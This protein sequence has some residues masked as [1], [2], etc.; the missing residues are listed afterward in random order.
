MILLRGKLVAKSPF[1]IGSGEGSCSDRDVLK[2]DNDKPFIPGTSLAGV[3]R[4]YFDGK[5]QEVIDE[6]FGKGEDKESKII[7]YDAFLQGKAH[8][9]VRDSVRLENRIAVDET[10]FD[11]EVI[12]E[13]ASFEFRLEI[14]YE[15]EI[16]K[17]LIKSI[18]EGF[19]RGEIR[20]GAKTSRGF[21]EFHV[22]GAV[23][24]ELDLS[25]EKDLDAYIDLEKTKNKHDIW[26]DVRE[27]KV[28]NKKNLVEEEK[29]HR[30]DS[31]V[32]LK[33]FLLIRDYSTVS[34]VTPKDNKS[35]FVD[36]ETLTNYRGDVV[37]PGTAWAGVF[38]H[39]CRRVLG[40]I[41]KREEEIKIFLDEYFGHETPLGE[42]GKLNHDSE[43]EKSKSKIIFSETRICKDSLTQ[44]NRTRTAIDRVSGSALQTGA[45]YTERA[46][47][48]KE[49]KKNEGD[50]S[51]WIKK[52]FD[53]KNDEIKKKDILIKNLITICLEDLN[54]GY[55]FV[56]GNT[57]VGGGLFEVKEGGG[58]E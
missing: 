16:S 17:I 8:L 5:N 40:K 2:D 23:F 6:I 14:D 25:K 44:L 49:D 10:K 18:I 15:D 55:L 41:G 13:G 56:G 58:N 54:K 32:S 19:N 28:D 4:H 42:D 53:E 46:A 9:S 3:C 21:G 30:I 48:I 47:F 24:L 11:Y 57:S 50:L 1:M 52:S 31:K 35:K 34:K 22:E 26:K 12:E 39:H 43:E 37:I 45:L 27:L 38:R 51:I 36:F 33:N 7:F 29:Y 20:L